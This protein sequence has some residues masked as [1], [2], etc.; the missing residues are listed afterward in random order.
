MNAYIS[1]NFYLCSGV[2]YQIIRS[3]KEETVYYSL[4]LYYFLRV[5]EKRDNDSST[6]F[7]LYPV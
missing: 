5:S 6:E 1:V 4:S 7:I 3:G 2:M